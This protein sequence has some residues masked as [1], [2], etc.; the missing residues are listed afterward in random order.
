MAKQMW[1]DARYFF[2]MTFSVYLLIFKI[3]IP[4]K[5][6]CLFPVLMDQLRPKMAD[7]KIYSLLISNLLCVLI[8]SYLHWFETSN[9]TAEQGKKFGLDS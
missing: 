3:S 8:N 4:S 9:G 1:Q 6:T 7:I 2:D 5:I